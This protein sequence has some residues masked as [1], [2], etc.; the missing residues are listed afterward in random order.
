MLF[1]KKAMAE[2]PFSSGKRVCNVAVDYTPANRRMSGQGRFSELTRER[3][4]ALDPS[5][6]S[7]EGLGIGRADDA[8]K[9][10]APIQ[11]LAAGC[12][13]AIQRANIQ[14]VIR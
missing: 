4:L 3:H 13:A 9:L 12:D 10:R 5:G 14:I 11:G 2:Q 1:S 8:M 6:W 7:C